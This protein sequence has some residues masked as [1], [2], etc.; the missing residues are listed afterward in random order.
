VLSTNFRE[1][2]IRLVILMVFFGGFFLVK[3]S[4]LSSPCSLPL[5]DCLEALRNSMPEGMA[6]VKVPKTGE[7]VWVDLRYCIIPPSVF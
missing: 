4:V 5:Q 2:T 3:R 1:I 6:L 7:L